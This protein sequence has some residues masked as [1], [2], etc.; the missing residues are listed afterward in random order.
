MQMIR[1]EYRDESPDSV[2]YIEEDHR[3]QPTLAAQSV[4]LLQIPPNEDDRSAYSFTTSFTD[5]DVPIFTRETVFERERKN[6]NFTLSSEYSFEKTH[7]DK[8]ETLFLKGLRFYMIFFL[9]E[10]EE[11]KSLKV[12]KSESLLFN[13]R[14]SDV[15]TEQHISFSL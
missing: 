1:K 6:V 11:S 12:E 13:K 3:L 8:V 7:F 15:I 14:K 2:G 5:M 10:G 9:C 4:R